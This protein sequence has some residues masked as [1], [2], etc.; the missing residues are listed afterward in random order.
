MTR[1]IV[2]WDVIE[3][4]IAVPA[5]VMA[6]SIALVG[7]GID[8]GIEGLRRL[9]GHD[10]CAVAAM[11]GKAGASLEALTFYVLAPTSASRPSGI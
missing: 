6:D 10:S 1:F 3:G 4:A 2:V 9:G 11:L 5:G 7:F 8:S